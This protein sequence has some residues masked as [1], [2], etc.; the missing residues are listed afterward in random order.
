M[1]RSS[2]PTAVTT[3][4][5][6][7]PVAIPALTGFEQ[8]LCRA[9]PGVTHDSER[10]DRHARRALVRGPRLPTAGL[11]RGAAR[12]R[13]T[14]ARARADVRSRVSGPLCPADSGRDPE[15]VARPRG[16]DEAGWR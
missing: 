10:L 16:A 1:S 9:G 3:S 5:H 6:D 12:L 4:R 11:T 2:R 14:A 8:H 15:H 7:E 13:R